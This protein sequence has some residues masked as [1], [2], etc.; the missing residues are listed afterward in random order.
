V[1]L[2][3]FPISLRELEVLAIKDISPRLRRITLGGQQ[4][5]AF[6]S[7]NGFSIPPFATE[8]PD[9]HIKIFYPNP[10]TGILSLP[11]QADGHLQWPRDP[12]ATSREYTPRNFDATAATC[13]FEFV[14]HE[15]GIATQWAANTKPGD[16]VFVAGPKA[17][18]IIPT[19]GTYLVA[20]DETALPAIANWLTMLPAEARVI[21]VILVEDMSATIALEHSAN[22]EI[23]WHLVDPAKPASFTEIIAALDLPTDDI[24]VW[25]AGEREAIRQLRSHL[26]DDR[27]IDKRRLDVSSYW[28][29]GV[30]DSIVAAAYDKFEALADLSGPMALRAAATYDFA[31]HV[32]SGATNLAAL[33]AASDCQI[34][35][36]E[37]LLPILIDI[38]VF[39]G[40]PESLGI[41]Q[42]GLILL[43][44]EHTREHLALTAPA[45]RRSFAWAGLVG[46]LRE[47]NAYK[48]LHGQ[49]YSAD[50]V[51]SGLVAAFADEH[52]HLVEDA[53]E[54]AAKLMTL[55]PG[56]HVVEVHGGAAAFL[57]EVAE[58]HPDVTGT[59]VDLPEAIPVA[60]EHIE[61]SA[62]AARLSTQVLAAN[63]SLPKADAYLL[64]GALWY[65]S[66]DE[67][68]ARLRAI[69]S[70]MSDG[71]RLFV[72]E[73]APSEHPRWRLEL[74]LSVGKARP[75]EAIAGLARAAGLTQ[76][77]SHVLEDGY[78]LFE[79]SI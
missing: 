63:A 72:L 7:G 22:A 43:E 27:Q 60:V 18:L 31:T 53:A 74:Q 24:F 2:K 51:S 21:C 46:A 40:T 8:G 69:V 17:S 48:R 50:A 38:D 55:P 12:V 10:E 14:L 65:L 13:D 66:D 5:S 34:D 68:I 39:T 61:A 15:H 47:G 62:H 49:S 58:R 76:R 73:P 70:N 37:P 64:G 52:A 42:M 35:I 44:D 26:I 30:D 23:S 33:A 19:A 78:G 59:L 25:A 71:N 79:F 32:A 4:M 16:K 36:L 3:R 67:A 9:D 11:V 56:A 6:T 28:H 45:G 75:L 77:A 20:G 1:A 57:L 29:H 41:G 54:D